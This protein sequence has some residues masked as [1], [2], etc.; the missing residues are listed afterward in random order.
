MNIKLFKGVRLKILT[1]LFLFVSFNLLA[2]EIGAIHQINS[3]AELAAVKHDFSEVNQG[4]E[5]VINFE[6]NTQCMAPVKQ[7]G[8]DILFL[9][10]SNCSEEQKAQIKTGL[11]VEKSLFNLI[12]LES[13]EEVAVFFAAEEDQEDTLDTI[14]KEG[15]EEA[16]AI[17][18]PNTLP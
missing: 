2:E 11:S 12:T 4:E 6:D 7:A 18:V 1:L 10:F 17:A 8:E 5:L 14:A 9:S 15:Q 3:Q 13:Q 16:A